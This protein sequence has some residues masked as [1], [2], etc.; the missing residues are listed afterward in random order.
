VPTFFGRMLNIAINGLYKEQKLLTCV[1]YL[2]TRTLPKAMVMVMVMGI[3]K[4]KDL[5]SIKYLKHSLSSKEVSKVRKMVLF[6]DF[7]F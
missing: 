4:K 5:G 6:T 7:F 2:M 3:V 1:C